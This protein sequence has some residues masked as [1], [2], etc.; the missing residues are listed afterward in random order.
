[1]EYKRMNNNNKKSKKE[2]KDVENSKKCVL[3]Q[4]G[5]VWE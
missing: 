3:E 1:M 4:E 2:T 5:I